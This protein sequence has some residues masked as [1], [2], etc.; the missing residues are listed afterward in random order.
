MQ[1]EP[2][3]IDGMFTGRKSIRTPFPQ[4]LLQFTATRGAVS[5]LGCF[6]CGGVFMS[7]V[8]LPNSQDKDHPPRPH[9]STS[10]SSYDPWGSFNFFMVEEGY[11]YSAFIKVS[12]NTVIM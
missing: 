8:L 6:L 2:V 3:W 4:S 5:I 12:S 11:Y 10:V 9:H 7:L 1:T